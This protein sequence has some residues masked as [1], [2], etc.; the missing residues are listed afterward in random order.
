LAAEGFERA[1][2][3]GR[4]LVSAQPE[5]LERLARG[6]RNDHG[7]VE[8]VLG[9]AIFLRWMTVDPV[10]GLAFANKERFT[11]MAWW[12]WGKTD[13]E[14]S[15]AAALEDPSPSVGAMVVRAIGQSD[16]LRARE[17]ID[18]YPHFEQH[19]AMQGMASGLM[20]ID[21]AAGA[22]MAAVWNDDFDKLVGGWAQRDP[23]AA[24]AWLAE[25]PDM[26]KRSEAL[27]RILGQMAFAHPERVGATIAALPDGATKWRA[28]ANH[29]KRLAATD[30][31]AARAWVEA[32]PT[33]LVRNEAT[34][35]LARGLARLSQLEA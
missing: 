12:A 28:Y 23:D 16:P 9:D 27:S 11:N 24:M 13:P 32:A 30:P 7:Y 35:A 5:D 8:M 31:E 17:L 21:P 1:E 6:L 14:A 3:L 15:L 25:L 20:D 22:T 29:A 4:F 10:G 33:P 2:R 18:L 26:T 19:L 34:V